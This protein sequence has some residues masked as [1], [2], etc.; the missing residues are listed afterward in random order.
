MKNQNQSRFV[1]RDGRVKVIR[2]PHRGRH[3]LYNSL[4]I[5]FVIVGIIG[6]VVPV[7]PTT[8][9]F[10]MA[11]GLFIT[12]NPQMYRWL[13]NN[14]LTGGYLRVYTQGTGLSRR[15]KAWSIGVLWATLAVSAWFVR[16]LPWLLGLLATVG[17]GVTWHVATIKPRKIS[18]EKLAAHNRIMN[19]GTGFP[20][21]L[22]NDDET[23][24]RAAGE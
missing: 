19:G 23:N 1:G 18:D 14:R 3:I 22:Q 21:A 15:S 12:T 6:I 24:G 17:I 10:I 20:S 13:H 9:F 8:V 2:S 7:L 4:G 16:E 5:A 11:S